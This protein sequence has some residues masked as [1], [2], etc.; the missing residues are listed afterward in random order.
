MA[1][2]DHL[3]RFL[4]YRQRQRKS[5]GNGKMPRWLIVLGV[6]AGLFV[7]GLS[8][9]AVGGIA[10]YQNCVSDL[11]PPDQA[12]E[13]LPRG[14]ARIYDR[15]GEL[16]FEYLNPEYGR[17]DPVPQDELSWWLSAA[18]IATEDASFRDNPGINIKGLGRAAW[19]NFSPFGNTPG[20]L[21]GTGGSSI[22]QQLVKN[23]YFPPEERAKR[24]VQ[25]KWKEVC[26]SIE[27]TRDND[28]E[29]ILTWYLNLISYGN[30]YT[31]AEAA[32]QGYFNKSARDLSLGEAALLAGIPASPTR[33]DPINNFDAARSRQLHVLERMQAEHYITAEMRWLAAAEPLKIHQQRFPIKAPHFVYYV[34][35]PEL[36]RLFGEEAKYRDGLEVHTTLNLKWQREAERILEEHISANES[37]YDGHNGAFVHIDP[38]TAQI[39]AYVGSR[40][41]FNKDISGENDMAGA[42]NS[43]GSSFKPFTYLTLLKE[44]GWG[45]GSYLLD[46]PYTYVDAAGSSFTP[47]NPSGC[48]SFQGP[49]TV[50]DALGNSLNVPA[51]KSILYAGVQN[52][53]AQAKLMGL[54]SLDRQFLGPALTTGGGDVRLADMVYGFTV[55]PNLGVLK[56]VETSLDLPPGN[57]AL[58]PVSIVRV[59]D[60]N[61]DLL[62]PLV[63]GKPTEEPPLREEQVAPPQETYMVTD[64]LVDP[65]AECIIFGCGRLSIPDN[66]P[67]AVKTGTSAPYETRGLTGDTWSIGYTP[68]IVAG[69]W[70]GNADNRPIGYQPSSTTVSWPVLQEYLDLYLRDKP[71]EQFTKPDGLVETEVCVLSNYPPTKDC[72]LE[73][74]T[75]FVKEDNLPDGYLQQLD[76]TAPPDDQGQGGQQ[77]Q[78][79][80]PLWDIAEVDTRSGLLASNLTPP[81]FRKRTLYLHLPDG[82]S[83]YEIGQA[84]EWVQRLGA[85]L[86]GAPKDATTQNDIPPQFRNVQLAITI[87]A[88]GARVTQGILAITGRATFNN[89]GFYRLEVKNSQLPGSN[90]VVAQSNQP[91]TDG[92][93]GQWDASLAPPGRY[94]IR[95][96]IID[97]IAGESSTQVTIDLIPAPLPQPTPGPPGPGPPGV[98][99][100][101]GGPPGQN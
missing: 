97:R 14:G 24:S 1:N 4:L 11:E 63:D 95:L 81:P 88:N 52:T 67:L 7:V 39:I 89:N 15:N 31:G 65:N 99:P 5:N 75:D 19:E 62:Y 18:T 96:I 8:V 27:L 100:G 61:G 12:I 94:V 85:A 93:L 72:P 32:S 101:G 46:T 87:P 16:L 44:R 28:K 58:D 40:D 42:L 23:V 21:E 35:Q 74:P 49:I 38:K 51:V 10:A 92:M 55:F 57:R 33:Y 22:T 91:V 60:R 48:G 50:R 13:K 3:H 71:V 34:V 98:G 17:R 36:D 70:Y 76:G 47:C 29:Q 83:A 53:I 80:D 73:T 59:E 56:G 43:P 26:Y 68:Q 9:A 30:I 25:R 77:F 20:F 45:P 78:G 2:N 66:R 79:D 41:F 86:G 69:T 82:T 37:S 64:I 84:Q 6:L 54:T 90:Q